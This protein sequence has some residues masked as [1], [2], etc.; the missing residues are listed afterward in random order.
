M[1]A[2]RMSNQSLARV[3]QILPGKLNLGACEALSDAPIYDMVVSAA[4]E[5]V[6]PQG[7]TYET[8]HLP[9]DDAPWDWR[10]NG[11]EAALVVGLART[12]AQA[13]QKGRYVL[14]VCQMGLN[15]SGLVTAL[16]LTHLGW[17]PDEAVQLVRARHPSVLSNRTFLN[18]VYG[19]SPRR[20]ALAS[21]L[22]QRR[23]RR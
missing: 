21:A 12:V 22:F 13:V 7:R 5:C 15:R 20:S 18:A 6:P 4:A 14:V 10:R 8:I 3:D 9:M 16:A 23:A 1:Y 2:G 19:L 17:P 11:D